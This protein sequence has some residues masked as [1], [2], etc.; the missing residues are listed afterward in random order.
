METFRVAWYRGF[1]RTYKHRI[2]I[3]TQLTRTQPASFN[4]TLARTYKW[5]TENHLDQANF[6]SAAVKLFYIVTN[7]TGTLHLVGVRQ[8]EPGPG[9]ITGSSPT[10]AID[11]YYQS[12]DLLN[13]LKLW[14][15]KH[16]KLT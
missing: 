5:Q 3:I 1:E 13:P 15:L 10:L 8:S 2:S 4:I 7:G 6:I 12:T 9:K 11:P 16:R 14:S